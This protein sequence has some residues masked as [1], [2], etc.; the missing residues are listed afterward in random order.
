MCYHHPAEKE[1]FFIFKVYNINMTLPNKGDRCV[2]CFQR[3]GLNRA[4]HIRASVLR[5]RDKGNKEV[6]IKMTSLTRHSL[7]E[8]RPQEQPWT[9]E[10]PMW[11]TTSVA[12]EATMNKGCCLSGN[13]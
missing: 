4:R 13:S 7:A 3:W 11:E 5:T 6:T 8:D 10:A 12:S 2:K 1:I 9:S